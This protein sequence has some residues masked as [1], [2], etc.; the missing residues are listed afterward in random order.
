VAVTGT[1]DVNSNSQTV[2]AITGAGNITLGAT[3][4]LTSSTGSSVTFSGVISDAGSVTK[5]GAGVWTLSGSNTYTGTTTISAGTLKLGVNNALASTTPVAVTGTF[6]VN[7]KT[8]TIAALSGAGGVTLGAGA[9]TS[10][11]SGSSTYSGAVSGTGSLTKAGTG[12][13]TL[14]GINTYTGATTVS[15]G[16]LSVTGSTTSSTTV[17]ASAT[18]KGTGT[19][20][21][22]VVVNGTMAPGAS[23]GTTN[24]VGAYTQSTGS[25]LEVE[26]DT[27]STDLL[28]VTGTVTI[29]PGATLALFPTAGSYPA[30]TSFT[31]ISSG[32]LLGSHFATVTTSDPSI[33]PTVVYTGTEVQLLFELPVNP[34]SPFTNLVYLHNP[35]R[36]AAYL[37]TLSPATGSDLAQVFD[38]LRDLDG[39]QLTHALDQMQPSAFKDFMLI[40]E[41]NLFLVEG[42]AASRLQV[43]NFSTC[44]NRAPGLTF[45]ID[46]AFQHNR[47]KNAARNAGYNANTMAVSVGMDTKF[48]DGFYVGTLLSFSEARARLLKSRGRGETQTFYGGVYG[49]AFTKTYFDLSTMVIGGT[50]RTHTRRNIA[51]PGLS[52]HAYGA[53]HGGEVLGHL[54]MGLRFKNRRQL[55][56]PYVS[57][58][59][60]YTHNSAFK[61]HGAES[62]DLSVK[63]SNSDVLRLEGGL[64]YSSCFCFQRSTGNLFI[65]AGLAHEERYLGRH[66][67]ARLR[68]QGG[69]FRVRGLAPDRYLLIPAIAYQQTFRKFAL[70]LRADGE[71]GRT[72]YSVNVGLQISLGQFSATC[73][74]RGGVLTHRSQHDSTLQSDL[75]PFHF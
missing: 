12:T 16:T 30:G 55:L 2:G 58:D 53:F 63:S 24:I 14:S 44:P 31:I 57:G 36:V 48:T 34:T 7:G 23:I 18:L 38:L 74:G 59:Y 72:F 5:A 32:G 50:H 45:W 75:S 42:S 21:G 28:N 8:Q 43:L 39:P 51:F 17:A 25:T 69:S 33:L 60:I 64:G 49:T 73:K 6:D 29:E 71:F 35:G 26:F 65:K 10:S 37:D 62:I 40:Q 19:I 52:R 61:E 46:D 41:E 13:L 4:A 9:L 47:Q 68:G 20:T 67:T 1:F 27:I 11:F 66:Y 70:A 15:A 56:R 3:G 22:T 54:D